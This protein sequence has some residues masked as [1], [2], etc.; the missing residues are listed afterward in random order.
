VAEI[1]TL[2]PLF[3]PDE[4]NKLIIVGTQS[5]GR[6]FKNNNNMNTQKKNFLKSIKFKQR[7]KY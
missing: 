7:V 2:R 5:K 3:T 1:C 6:A 4:R